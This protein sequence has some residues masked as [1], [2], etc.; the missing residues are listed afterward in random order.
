VCAVPGGDP[1]DF[2]PPA[3]DVVQPPEF[4]CL[5]PPAPTIPTMREFA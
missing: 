4:A 1:K 2:F 3:H 5:R